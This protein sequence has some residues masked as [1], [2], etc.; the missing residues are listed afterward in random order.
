[1]VASEPLGLASSAVLLSNG[2]DMCLGGMHGELS[3]MSER[4]IF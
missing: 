1:M 4:G 3:V 2:K